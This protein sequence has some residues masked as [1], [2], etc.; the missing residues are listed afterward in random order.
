MSNNNFATAHDKL[1]LFGCP[2]AQAMQPIAKLKRLALEIVMR[3]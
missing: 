1:I 2:R 3:G